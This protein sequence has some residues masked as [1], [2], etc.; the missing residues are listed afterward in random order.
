LH[1]KLK[2]YVTA[3]HNI[4]TNSLAKRELYKVDHTVSK[5]SP[6]GWF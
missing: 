5:N 6:I 3:L 4:A 2:I 1:K